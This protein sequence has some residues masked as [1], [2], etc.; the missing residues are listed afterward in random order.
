M[1]LDHPAIGSVPDDHFLAVLDAVLPSRR[2]VVAV[3][4][5][6]FD[7]SERPDGTFCVAGFAFAKE[8]VKKFDKEWWALFGAY[9]GCHMKELAHRTGR[10]KGISTEE[11]IR[12]I[13]RAVAIINKRTSF[14]IAVSCYTD[15]MAQVLPKWIDGFQGAYPV[16]CHMA[17]TALGSKV[18]ESGHDDEIAY[19]FESG[20]KHSGAAHRFMGKADESPELKAS[21]RHRSHTFIGRDSALP[22]QSADIFAWE[23]TKYWDETAQKRIRLM[24]K[25]L[26]ALL[27]KGAAN[28]DKKK[29]KLL[30]L[31]GPPLQRFATSV[32]RLGLLQIEEDG[33]RKNRPYAA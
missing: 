21:Y 11:S 4:K 27:S 14:G 29:Y 19:F 30:H 1:I 31:S 20:D 18:Q 13:K 8:Q 16:C 2:G 22:L 12:L 6:Y 15:E 3:L 32:A 9:G 7:A 5:A 17:M 23:F 10:F 33:I 28:Y 25:S 26:V 24:R